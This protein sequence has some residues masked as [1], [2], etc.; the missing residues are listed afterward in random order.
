MQAAFERVTDIQTRRHLCIATMATSFDNDELLPPSLHWVLDSVSGD[1]T[2]DT[3]SA[4]YTRAS[5]FY[6]TCGLVA[7]IAKRSIMAD[8]DRLKA[9]NIPEEG[10]QLA[11][12]QQSFNALTH[13]DPALM[14]TWTSQSTLRA[15]TR[16]VYQELAHEFWDFLTKHIRCI[17]MVCETEQKEGINAMPT[18]L[19]IL[20]HL[21]ST[22]GDA[23]NL[24]AGFILCELPFFGLL[25]AAKVTDDD[26]VSRMY[27]E[28]VYDGNLHE[29]ISLY[30]MLKQIHPRLPKDSRPA[31]PVFGIC[32]DH[33]TSDVTEPVTDLEI[34]LDAF[35]DALAFL[36][37]MPIEE[38]LQDYATVGN[39]CT[40]VISKNESAALLIRQ[41]ANSTDQ[42][43]KLVAL[44]A[45]EAFTGDGEMSSTMFEANMAAVMTAWML[46]DDAMRSRIEAMTANPSS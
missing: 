10:S 16:D 1:I 37:K 22:V 6:K 23:E 41:L 14:L 21:Y 43:Y 11:I 46:A 20:G 33:N 13:G 28:L 9:I 40:M 24:F 31:L 44:G 19:D 27:E 8:C 7:S 35:D 26:Y 25:T 18:R 32:K 17:N 30:D 29:T 36:E 15:S 45:V 38:R 39:L 5:I 4:M 12:H 3:E 34:T 2:Y 42:P